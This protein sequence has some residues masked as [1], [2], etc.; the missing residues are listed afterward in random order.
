M[1]KYQECCAC[2]W[3]VHTQMH[4]AATV[5]GM[6]FANT[7]LGA[8]H[9]ECQVSSHNAQPSKAVTL[10]AAADPENSIKPPF[11]VFQTLVKY[12]QVPGQQWQ[13][14][15]VPLAMLLCTPQ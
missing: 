9:C 13:I 1:T 8:C 7:F 10:A 6:A 14:L 5:A 11:I 4:N 3:C 2:L 15:Q 12:C